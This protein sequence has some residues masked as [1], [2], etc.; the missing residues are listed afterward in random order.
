MSISEFH[1]LN[2]NIS[3]STP[4]NPGG[5][6]SLTDVMC[7]LA[8]AFTPKF[9]GKI[10]IWVTAQVTN[11]LLGD[12]IVN[13]I[14]YGTGTAPVN[15]AAVTGTSTGSGVKMIAAI[16]NQFTPM[17]LVGYATGLTLNT[18]YWV[19]LTQ[20]AITAGTAGIQQITILIEE[21]QN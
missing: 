11:T 18:A 15:G 14:R 8:I 16:N 10:K 2:S 5:T 17:A 19:D 3:I 7:G 13:G 9:T 6:T 20:A 4:G 1:V 21:I 12:G